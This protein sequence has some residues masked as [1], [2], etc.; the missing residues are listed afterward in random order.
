MT[1]NCTMN[2]CPCVAG[3]KCDVRMRWLPTNGRFA[4]HPA[5]D[6]PLRALWR[7][8]LHASQRSRLLV[9]IAQCTD[10]TCPTCSTACEVRDTNATLSTGAALGGVAQK[11]LTCN[12]HLAFHSTDLP[13]GPRSLLS[14]QTCGGSMHGAAC[15]CTAGNCACSE[16]CKCPTC[17]K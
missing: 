5:S 10:C 6:V 3:K 16:A 13:G 1:C 8:L 15:K 17:K 9:T 11:R 12:D 4:H 14:L 7:Q 2:T